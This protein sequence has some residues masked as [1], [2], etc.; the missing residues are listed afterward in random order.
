[1]AIR[2]ALFILFAVLAGLFGATSTSLWMS[3]ASLGFA[4]LAAAMVLDAILP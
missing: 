2:F 1:M 4:I 3:G